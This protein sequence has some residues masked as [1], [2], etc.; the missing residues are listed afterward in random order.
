MT[1]FN[2]KEWQDKHLNEGR[3]VNKNNAEEVEYHKLAMK[4]YKKIKNIKIR[5]YRYDSVYG[6]VYLKCKD[7]EEPEFD[8]G[9]MSL[10]FPLVMSIPEWHDDG[11]KADASMTKKYLVNCEKALLEDTGLKKIMTEYNKIFKH[12]SKKPDLFV[13]KPEKTSELVS[14]RKHYSTQY[15]TYDVVFYFSIAKA[16]K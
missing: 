15:R 12:I 6:G 4:L 3:N 13:T 1:K 11:N 2:I 10:P 9:W 5:I 14:D 8:Y 16:N 7:M